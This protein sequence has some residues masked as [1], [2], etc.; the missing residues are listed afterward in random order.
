MD[1]D[2]QAYLFGIFNLT[3]AFIIGILIGE[4]HNLNLKYVLYAISNGLIFYL[5]NYLTTVCLKYIAVSKFQPITY[6]MIVF[7][8]IL[9]GVLLGEPEFLTDIIG[10][11]II[12]FSNFI[13]INNLLEEP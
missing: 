10:A 5:A 4:F 6:L 13:I 9:S 2:L 12:I 3:P 8:F 11:A 1:I 7:T